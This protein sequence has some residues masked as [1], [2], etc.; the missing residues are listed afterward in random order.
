M[1]TKTHRLLTSLLIS[2]FLATACATATT[3]SV[4]QPSSTV[5]V[6]ASATPLVGVASPTLEV[7]AQPSAELTVTAPVDALPVA[8]SRGPD[9]HATDPTTV[10]LATGQL[11]F[12]EFFRFT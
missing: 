4:E 7:G 5:A 2:V 10:N 8:T 12:V 9:L 11:H 3:E 6:D 1:A